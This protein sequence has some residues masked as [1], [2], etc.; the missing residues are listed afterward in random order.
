MQLN[1]TKRDGSLFPFNIDKIKQ[2]IAWACEGLDVNPIELESKVTTV[3]VEG[4]STRTIQDNLIQH[5]VILTSL[6]TPDWKNVA[7]RL[8]MMNHWKETKLARGY[9]YGDYYMYL[10]DMVA[11]GKYDEKI[12][13]EYTSTELEE[14]GYWID[15]NL[16]LNYDYAGVS[17]LANPNVTK[18]YLVEGELLQEAYLS[19]SLLLASVEKKEERLTYA[20]KF[21]TLLSSNKL[22]LATPFLIN[23]R[24]PKGN[25][26]SCFLVAMSDDL[27]S[28]FDTIH[29]IA[30]ISKRGGGV[31]LDL[32]RIRAAGSWVDKKANASNGVCSWIKIVNDTALAVNQ[33]K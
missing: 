9:S 14:A 20:K 5:A 21:Y 26:S 33:G 11:A 15:P 7:G 1:I 25:V 2:V 30:N 8:M 17:I 23:L 4:V 22:S 10:V 3:F 16:D 31:G 18:R 29:K 27:D 6:E 12:L 24:R 32:S 19:I 13:K 28:I